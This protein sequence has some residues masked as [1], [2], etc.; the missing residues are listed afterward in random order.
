MGRRTRAE[1]GFFYLATDSSNR[2]YFV[3]DL[4]GHIWSFAQPIKG[5]AG[6][7]PEGWSIEI[8]K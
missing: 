6:P 2:R 8:P 3:A 7:P 5:R 4:E 1:R